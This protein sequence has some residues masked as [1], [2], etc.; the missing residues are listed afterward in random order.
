VVWYALRPL[1][2]GRANRV[3]HSLEEIMLVPVDSRSASVIR[4]HDDRIV[5]KEGSASSTDI[6][7]AAVGEFHDLIPESHTA[8]S[9]AILIHFPFPPFPSDTLLLLA[10]V[11]MLGAVSSLAREPT[12]RSKGIAR[13]LCR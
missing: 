11:P 1:G 12:S 10:L 4:S 7:F 3:V 9:V 8:L 2:A 5:V 13:K 6:H